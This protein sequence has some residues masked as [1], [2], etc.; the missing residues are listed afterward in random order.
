M[1][2]SL[3]RNL[4]SIKASRKGSGARFAILKILEEHSEG[5]PVMLIYKCLNQRGLHITH[6]AVFQNM[7]VLER[8]GLVWKTRVFNKEAKRELW[9]YISSVPFF[10][11]VAEDISKEIILEL[12]KS[13]Q[14]NIDKAPRFE[15]F[16]TLQCFIENVI[17]HSAESV[18]FGEKL[19]FELSKRKPYA[20][21]VVLIREYTKA[22]STIQKAIETNTQLRGVIERRTNLH[23]PS[24]LTLRN[25]YDIARAIVDGS[26]KGEKRY[27]HSID[28]LQKNTTGDLSERLAES[29]AWIKSRS[30][31]PA[32]G[33]E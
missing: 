8:K 11:S 19:Y 18:I 20:E 16:L 30:G 1:D 24:S 21:S 33:G 4:F 13:I 23:L 27:F 29:S 26:V 9:Y 2:D 22:V 32:K 5:L 15:D 10:D 14:R 3:R 12:S 25:L 17:L 7:E 6:P 28:F 31:L